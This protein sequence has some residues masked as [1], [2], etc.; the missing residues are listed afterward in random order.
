MRFCFG[1][2]NVGQLAFYVQDEWEANDNLKL[3]YGIRFDKPLF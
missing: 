2:N 1:R 3:T